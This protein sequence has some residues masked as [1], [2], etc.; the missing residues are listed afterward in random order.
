MIELTP[1]VANG[2]APVSMTYRLFQFKTK[3][4]TIINYNYLLVDRA[5]HQA[6]VVDPAWDSPK[7][8]SSIEEQNA[9]LTMILVTHSHFD[10]TNLIEPLLKRYPAQVYMSAVEEEYY[11]FQCPNLQPINHLDLIQ[12]GETPISCLHTP[13]HTAGST[14]YLAP[15][16]LFTGD[17]IFTEGCGICNT[18][19]GS[20]AGMFKSIE[21]IKKTVPPGTRIYPAHSFGLE[22]GATLENLQRENIYFQFDDPEKFIEFRMRKNQKN[23]FNFC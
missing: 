5:S 9:E 4:M 22:P 6:A 7:I 8:I 17:T 14:C 13:G 12:L 19:G 16:S 10:H 2:K 3:F 1:L 18:I 15:D 23:L 11:G 20:P 21:M